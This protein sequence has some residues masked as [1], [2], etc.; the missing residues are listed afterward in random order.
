MTAFPSLDERARAAL[1]ERG[2]DPDVS[3]LAWLRRVTGAPA[4]D[5]WLLELA[6]MNPHPAKE[7]RRR[8]AA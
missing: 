5:P 7:Y 2:T 3:L 4:W 6:R 1:A 8:E